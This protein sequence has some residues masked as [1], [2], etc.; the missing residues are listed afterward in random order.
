MKKGSKL[1][2]GTHDFSTFRSSSCGAKSPI[3][4]MENISI[5]KNE[6]KKLSFVK[7]IIISEHNEMDFGSWKVGLEFIKKKKKEN[8]L[9]LNDS[10]IGPFVNFKFILENT[11]FQK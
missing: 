9:L 5:K 2:L 8:V 3:K 4:T 7:K 1:L 6:Q 11:K 10:I